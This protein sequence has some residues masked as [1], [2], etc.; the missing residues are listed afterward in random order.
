M[1][2]SVPA[3]PAED[4]DAQTHP[5]S[6]HPLSQSKPGGESEDWSNQGGGKK[7]SKLN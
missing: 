1:T 3:G 5:D 4:D 2:V 7:F 6:P